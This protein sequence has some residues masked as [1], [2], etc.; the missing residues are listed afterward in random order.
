MRAFG[1]PRGLISAAFLFVAA[2]IHAQANLS[3]YTDNLVNGFQ[4]W[5]YTSTRNF[6]NTTPTNS[7]SHSISITIGS[8][9]GAL[10]LE[11]PSDAGFDTT[12]YTSISFWINGGSAGGQRMQIYSR[13]G[14]NVQNSS[15][16]S[17]SKL[18]TNAWQHITIPLSQLGAASQ[19]NFTGIGIQSSISSAQPVFYV[20]DIALLA[21]ATPGTVHIGVDASQDLRTVDA[22]QFGANTATWD[23]H[24]NDSSTR[25]R[26]QEAGVLALRWP[27]GSTSDTYHWASDPTG[28][29][30][31]NKLATNLNAQVFITVNY[32]SGTSDEAAAWV[33][34]DNVTNH[35]GFKYWEI[36]NECYGSWETNLNDSTH[37]PFTYATRAADYFQAMKNADRTIKIGVVAVPGENSFSNNATHFEINSRTGDKHYGWTPVVLATLKSLGTTPDFLIYHFYPQYSSAGSTASADS[38]PL[39]LQASVNWANDAADL[40]QQISDYLG[41]GGTNIELVCTENNSDSGAMGRQS[42]SVVNALYLADNIGQILK[43]EFRSYFWW[44]AHNGSDT[45]GSFD[46]T[47][48]GW[49]ANGDY[50]LL[51]AANARYPSFY[52]EKLVQYF[53]RPGDSVLP[54]SSD[55]LLLSAYAVRRTNGALTMLVINKDS[56]ATFNTQ[57]GITNYP[58]N[59]HATIQSYGIPQD[60]AA[61]TNGSATLQDISKTDFFSAGTNFNYSFPPYSLTLFTFAPAATQLAASTGPQGQ[62]I[63]QL[64][65]QPNVPYVIQT[66]SNLSNW[67]SIST[68]V[69]AGNFVNLTNT[70]APGTPRQFLRAV[71]QP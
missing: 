16:V 56:A 36:G 65:G 50:G 48:Y 69:M 37:D 66:S 68:N 18:A 71:W 11:Q 67:V 42:T 31:F 29:A 44:D 61:R 53:T 2:H 12:P 49:R 23:A 34:S 46:P 4:D 35:C 8:N 27:G 17:L 19:T 15:M 54:A 60:E 7:G 13:L 51:S 45:S 3:L 20:D 21:A 33:L 40:R 26:L 59:A 63:L 43:T 28:N 22:R 41:P 70:I 10:D 58:P 1:R 57:I 38:D 39:L 55:Y 64:Q 62:F 14:H 47:L 24:L 32:G 25:T 30:N 9:Y 6:A 5:G 52:A